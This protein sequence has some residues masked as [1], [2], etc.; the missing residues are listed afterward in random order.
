MTPVPVTTILRRSICPRCQAAGVF[1]PH[2][3]GEGLVPT[4]AAQRPDAIAVVRPRRGG[5]GYATFD[6]QLI[7]EPGPRP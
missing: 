5:K 1:C 7:I 6:V 3:A 2:C 4:P